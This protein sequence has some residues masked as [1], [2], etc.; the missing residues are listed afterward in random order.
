MKSNE[1]ADG[2][3]PLETKMKPLSEVFVEGRVERCSVGDNEGYN[4]GHKESPKAVL[5]ETNGEERDL[6][7]GEGYSVSRT[8]RELESALRLYVDLISDA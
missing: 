4:E 7:Q 3:R 8:L 1:L 6:G 2:L 5:F